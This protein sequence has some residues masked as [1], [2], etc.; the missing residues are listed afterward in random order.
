MGAAGKPEVHHGEIALPSRNGSERHPGTRGARALRDRRAVE[1][2]R[3]RHAAR[4]RGKRFDLLPLGDAD[5]E[6]RK[7][8]VERQ[9][10]PAGTPRRPFDR[11]DVPRLLIGIVARHD[12]A[13]IDEPPPL[14]FRPFVDVESA[15]ARGRHVRK[16]QLGI[17]ERPPQRNLVRVGHEPIADARA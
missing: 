6:I 13:P 12:E 5:R 3:L 15:H 16:S 14:L 1:H 11:V 9:V 10:D 4:P 8:V 2:D 7:S 17:G